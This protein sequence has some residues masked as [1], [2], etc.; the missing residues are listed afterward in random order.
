MVLA[1]GRSAARRFLARAGV[2][3]IVVFLVTVSLSKPAVHADLSTLTPTRSKWTPELNL[4]D[5]PE[6][7]CINGLSNGQSDLKPGAEA[8]RLG[9]M[10]RKNAWS[11]AGSE[12]GA[13]TA[14]QWRNDLVGGDMLQQRSE[15]TA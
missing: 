8:I 10:A 13:T 3:A 14:K 6:A 7:K 1:A 2:A 9:R 5:E 12:A 11:T 4:L 15:A